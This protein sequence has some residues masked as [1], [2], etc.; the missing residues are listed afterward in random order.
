MARKR[1]G[2]SAP[3][4]HQEPIALARKVV[5]LLDER[6]D[7]ESHRRAIF[8]LLTNGPCFTQEET[9]AELKRLSAAE[10][11][12]I[13]QALQVYLRA[14]VRLTIPRTPIDLSGVR[15]YTIRS[16]HSAISFM[17]GPLLGQA[18]HALVLLLHLV[19][20]ENL[21][22]CGASDCPRIFVK[23][24]RR[25]FCSERCQK[26]T[27]KRQERDTARAARSHTGTKRK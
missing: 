14:A 13:A 5:T 15:V 9:I 3:V 2:I 1:D 21:W 17:D 27:Y 23:T 7:P 11:A 24:Y 16:G 22:P 20:F 8:N 4:V 26:R 6:T 12:P 10:I 25:E 19:G 18:G